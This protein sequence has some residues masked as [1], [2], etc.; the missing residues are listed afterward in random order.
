MAQDCVGPTLLSAAFDFEFLNCRTSL[1]TWTNP[2]QRRRTG[3]SAPH[4]GSAIIFPG[5]DTRLA[6]IHPANQ[7]VAPPRI[8]LARRADGGLSGAHRETE[9]TAQCFH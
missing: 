8:R 6:A 3:V 1:L 4:T 5:D 2:S 9:P 7:R